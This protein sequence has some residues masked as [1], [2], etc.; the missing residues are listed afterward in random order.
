MNWFLSSSFFSIRIDHLYHYRLFQ[1]FV[2]FL[3]SPHLASELVST[4]STLTVLTCWN[5]TFLILNGI[6][7]RVLKQMVKFPGNFWTL[8]NARVHITIHD[9]LIELSESQTLTFR[10]VRYSYEGRTWKRTV[11]N[12]L[13]YQR[14]NRAREYFLGTF[15]RNQI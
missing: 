6:F 3:I 7:Q 5:E 1:I 15:V 14:E 8:L 2:T 9:V 4:R 12:R 13:C 10:N 11:L